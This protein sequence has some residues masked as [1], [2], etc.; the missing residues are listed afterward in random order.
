[1]D[2]LTQKEKIELIDLAKRVSDNAYSPY[3]NLKVG[4]AVLTAHGEIFTGVNIEN[5]S[6]S[7]TICAERVAMSNAISH[8][9]TD[10]K[11]IAIFT[12]KPDITPCGSCRQFIR[13]FGENIQ[14]IYKDHDE[15][16]TKSI[17]QMLPNA[18]TE[19]KL[20]Q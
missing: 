1:M 12:S 6:Y 14:V 13:E 8:G 11:A 4:A 2:N 15:I 18:F 9:N 19:K 7:L 5:A 17:S 3:S 20:N 10:I 16:I